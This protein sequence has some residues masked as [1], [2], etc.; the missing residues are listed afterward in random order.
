MSRTIT[1]EILAKKGAAHRALRAAVD[2]KRAAIEAMPASADPMPEAMLR[3]LESAHVAAN[4]LISAAGQGDQVALQIH[5]QET[6]LGGFN[7]SVMIDV[8]T[9]TYQA[10]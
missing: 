1:I 9:P 4:K 2:E 6:P 3:T 5:I 10:A 8:P 7:A